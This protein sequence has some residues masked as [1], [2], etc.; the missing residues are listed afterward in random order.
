MLTTKWKVAAIVLATTVLSGCTVTSGVG[1]GVTSAQADAIL[2]ELRDI[3][4]VLAEQPRAARA[5][6]AAKPV[7]VRAD[8]GPSLGNADAPVT[9]VEYTDYQCPFCKRHHDGTY[10]QLK[11]NYVDTGKVRYVIR[12]LPLSFHAQAQPAAIAAN[13]AADQGRFWQAHD[14]LFEKQAELAP[15]TIRAAV[16][17]AGVDA[18]RYDACIAKPEAAAAVDAD[19]EEARSIGITGTPSFVVGRRV[20][21]AIEGTVI[22]GAQPYAA[23]VQRIDALLG[24][25]APAVRN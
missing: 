7:R 23:F 19:A 11:K 25:A 16:V 20:D 18:K 3:K 9:I 17:G 15:E 21:G 12:D 5:E 24:A 1:N 22:A 6:P 8:A 13:C 14:A 2:A 10:A 4:R